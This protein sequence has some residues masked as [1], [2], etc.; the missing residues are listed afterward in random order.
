MSVPSA[1]HVT[2]APFQHVFCYYSIPE[3][4]VSD[5]S[6]VCLQ[7][8]EDIFLKT[9]DLRQPD[10]LID[11]IPRGQAECTIQELSRYLQ[12]YCSSQQH[13]WA[14]FLPWAKYA[15]NSLWHYATWL[16]PLPMCATDP[17]AILPLGCYAHRCSGCGRLVP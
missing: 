15:Q 1:K 16:T 5:G 2:E 4:I 7:G 12:A 14:E 6:P 13:D 8:V 11:V 3:D 10:Y 17:N 9:G